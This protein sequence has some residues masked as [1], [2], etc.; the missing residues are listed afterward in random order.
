MQCLYQHRSRRWQKTQT[1]S[2]DTVGPLHTGPGTG[3]GRILPFCRRCSNKRKN[4]KG[5]VRKVLTYIQKALNVN[6]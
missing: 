1:P 2:P 5:G 3:P 4:K 6:D